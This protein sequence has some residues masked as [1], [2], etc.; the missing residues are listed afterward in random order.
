MMLSPVCARSFRR[1]QRRD[2]ARDEVEIILDRKIPRRF[3]G[4]LP[5]RLLFV[6][7]PVM[8][9]YGCPIVKTE[10]VPIADRAQ[11]EVVHALLKALRSTSTGSRG[12]CRAL[13]SIW[14]AR[15]GPDTVLYSRDIHARH[16]N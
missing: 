9:E 13:A 14:P 3:V 2:P 12:L 5:N 15:V 10:M 4:L 11:L 1:R 6:H 16:V 7:P 8:P